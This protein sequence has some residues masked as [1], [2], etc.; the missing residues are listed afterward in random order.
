MTTTDNAHIDDARLAQDRLSHWC[1]QVGTYEYPAV[2]D[3][4]VVLTEID[5]LRDRLNEIELADALDVQQYCEEMEQ[6]SPVEGEV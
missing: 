2:E 5:R 4:E 3:V 6:P 1:Q